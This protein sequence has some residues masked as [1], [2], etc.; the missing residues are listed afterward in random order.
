MTA[1]S[2]GAVEV[3]V[4]GRP[5]GTDLARRIV[6]VRVATRLGTPAQCELAYATLR[7][8]AAEHDRMPLGADIAVRLTGQEVP[9]FSGEV[10]CLTLAHAADT[11]T[12][13]RVRCYDRLHRLRKRQQLRVFTKLTA[14]ELA[15][16]VAGD[17]GLSVL[18]GEQGPVFE[19]IVQHHQHDFT[20]LTSVAA[21]AGLYPVAEGDKLHLVTL[22][23]HGEPVELELGKTLLEAEVEANLEQGCRRLTALGWNTRTA[24]V[25]EERVDAPRIGRDVELDPDPAAVEVDA[26]LYL[27][28]R[29]GSSAE[30]VAALAQAELDRRAQAAVTLTGVAQG[31]ARLAAGRRITVRG[32]AEPLAGDY[33]LTE[34]VHTVDATGY[35]TSLSTRPPPGPA[36]GEAAEG[37]AVTLGVVTNVDDPDGLG[38]VRVSLAAHGAADVGWLGVLCPGAGRDKGLVILPDTG[39]TVLVA[40]PHGLVGGLVLGSLYGGIE[41]ADPGVRDGA[42]KRWSLRTADGQAVVVDDAEHRITVADRA[43]S[44]LDLAP[45][46]VVLHAATDLVIQAPGR[47]ITVRAKTV[48]FVQAPVGEDP[49]VDV[50]PRGGR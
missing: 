29:R 28:D 50:G 8:T 41:P 26:D 4:D 14:V 24:E 27:V 37:S 46:R 2:V 11:G 5:L 7:G 21:S 38:R 12:T 42:V 10:T 34:A 36:T 22:S 45:D 20:L 17:L 15:K 48:D 43:G 16:E 25:I 30:E 39:D 44:M 23:G 1:V 49:P 35:L 40:L 33:V 3:T 19:R 31:D 9:L 47:A 13:L 32:L 6:S 18:A